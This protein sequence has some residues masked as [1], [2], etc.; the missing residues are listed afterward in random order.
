[1]KFDRQVRIEAGV[2]TDEALICIRNWIKEDANEA[3]RDN[4]SGGIIYQM[5]S[6]NVLFVYRTKTAYIARKS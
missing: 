2:D 3:R 4:Y 1:M 6:G 5:K